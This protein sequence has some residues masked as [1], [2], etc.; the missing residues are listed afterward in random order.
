MGCSSLI[1]HPEFYPPMVRMRLR[2]LV[3]RALPKAAKV[4]CPTEHVRIETIETFGL[5][6]DRVT[7]IPVGV[8]PIFRCIDESTV[9]AVLEERYAVR[10]PYFLFSGRWEKRKNILRMIEAFAL[11]KRTTRCEHKFVLTGDSTWAA[12]EVAATISRLGIQDSVVDLGNTPF[13][14]L[15]YLY[16]G[17]E[18]LMYASLWEGFGLPIVE[19]MACGTPVITSTV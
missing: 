17:A 15:P 16:C 13:S 12:D 5:P 10:F 2:F 3:H 11:F 8:D 6:A 1:R 4:I 14:D 9:R 19:S 7:V 18:A